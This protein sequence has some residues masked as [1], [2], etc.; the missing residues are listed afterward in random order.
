MQQ[1]MQEKIFEALNNLTEKVKFLYIKREKQ[2][3]QIAQDME[4]RNIECDNTHEKVRAPMES[5]L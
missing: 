2:G 4:V 1:D 3:A 5:T